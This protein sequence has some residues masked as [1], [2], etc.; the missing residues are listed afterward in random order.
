MIM[1]TRVVV[2]LA[3]AGFF[4][5]PLCADVIPTR[6]ESGSEAAQKMESRLAELG[7]D[8]RVAGLHA[9][10]LTEEETAYF[11]EQPAR[12]QMAGQEIF[13]GQ[14]DNFWWEWLFGAAALAGT[15]ALIYF[16]AFD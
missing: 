4:S 9:R 14:S 10:Q 8:A 12:L 2:A 15:G 11:T 1:A 7:M 6:Y 5:L 13:G 3:V 16:I